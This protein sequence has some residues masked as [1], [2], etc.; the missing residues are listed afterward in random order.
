MPF[1]TACFA[2]EMSNL[3]QQKLNNNRI[4]EAYSLKKVNE[5]VEAFDDIWQKVRIFHRKSILY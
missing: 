5:G 2:Y 3:A 4:G 1:A